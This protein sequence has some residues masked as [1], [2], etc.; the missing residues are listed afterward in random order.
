MSPEMQTVLPLVPKDDLE[1]PSDLLL[2][3]EQGLELQDESLLCSELQGDL[4][5]CLGPGPLRCLGHRRVLQG[6]FL[7][8]LEHGTYTAGKRQGL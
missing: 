6:V 4:L 8:C 2:R 1:L 7:R 5:L 3:L